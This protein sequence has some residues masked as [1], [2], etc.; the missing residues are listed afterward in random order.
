MELY[1]LDRK[2]I[3]GILLPYSSFILILGFLSVVLA[4][5]L[6][7]KG[8]EEL[9]PVQ[10]KVAKFEGWIHD[11]DT[12]LGCLKGEE[13]HKHNGDKDLQGGV[14]GRLGHII[15]PLMNVWQDFVDKNT[16]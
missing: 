7:R 6:S 12:C 14:Q 4:W 8:E 3:S 1:T 2:K 16:T 10:P 5:T 11:S 13:W 9:D 15:A